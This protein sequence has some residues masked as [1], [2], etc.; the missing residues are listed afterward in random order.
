MPPLEPSAPHPGELARKYC[1]GGWGGYAL[2]LFAE[3]EERDTFVAAAAGGGAGGLTGA[4]RVT[5]VDE[6][7]PA[8]VAS[9]AAAAVVGGMKAQRIAIEPYVRPV[10]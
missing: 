2:Y 9:A 7:E 5:Q 8:G 10:H 3:R 4:G 1:G 6:G